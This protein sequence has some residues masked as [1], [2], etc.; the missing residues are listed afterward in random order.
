[1]KSSSTASAPGK[2]IL[3][4]EHFVVYG[5]PAILSSIDKRIVATAKINSANRTRID[6]NFKPFRSTAND[7]GSGNNNADNDDLLTPIYDAINRTFGRTER[8]GLDITLR[9]EIPVGIGLGSSASACIA[10]IAAVD[11]LFGRSDK[12]R[13]CNLAIESERLV[14]KDTS[15]ADCY[16]STFGGMVKFVKSTGMKTIQSKGSL[17]F[18]VADTG[19]PHLTGDM[20]SK[21][22]L[23]KTE[24]EKR[25][26]ALSEKVDRICRDAIPA[27]S[28]GDYVTLG[29][30]MND[31]QLLLDEIGVTHPKARKIIEMARNAG[32]LGAKVTGA[33]GGGAVIV[34]TLP[35]RARNLVEEIKNAGYD[36]FESKLEHAGVKVQSS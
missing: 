23:Y 17:S 1:M 9:T 31:N 30:L 32:A 19:I 6:S 3:F 14:H 12:E 21:V 28:A 34:L 18:I 11:S 4:G 35:N 5:S 2:I 20:V 27:L 15:G 22:R 13:I 36:C 24:N 10:T 7:D 25:F 29:Q 8:I 26:S 16:V 33:G